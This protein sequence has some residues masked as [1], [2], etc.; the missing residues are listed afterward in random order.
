MAKNFA[1]DLLGI[2]QYQSGGPQSPSLLAPKERTREHLFRPP[3]R[4]ERSQ[5]RLPGAV[6]VV[7]PV[8]VIPVAAAAVDE[9]TR[10]W[11]G[12]PDHSRHAPAAPPQPQDAEE[13]GPARARHFVKRTAGAVT[14]AAVEVVPDQM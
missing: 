13:V 9:H 5:V 14:E 12:P 6:Q 4:C 8:D 2:R 3:Q 1:T 10:V 7:D 11:G